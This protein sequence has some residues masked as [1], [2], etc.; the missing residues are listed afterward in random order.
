[1]KMEFKRGVWRVKDDNGNIKKFDVKE[2]AESYYKRI[3]GKVDS[4]KSKSETKR[5]WEKPDASKTK[6]KVFLDKKDDKEVDEKENVSKKETIRPTVV[7]IGKKDSP[8]K[9]KEK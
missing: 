8:S 5:F 6:A 3:G 9:S 7:G 4:P 2:A 1:M